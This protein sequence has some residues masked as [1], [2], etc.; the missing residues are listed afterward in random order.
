VV[1]GISFRANR[2]TES[3]TGIPERK[4]ALGK[5]TGVVSGYLPTASADRANDAIA[6][7]YCQ[8]E[9]G[10]QHRSNDEQQPTSRKGSVAETKQ[11][12]ADADRENPASRLTSQHG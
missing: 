12:D 2:R 5:A 10:C 3:T 1:I 4:C 11:G 8:D 6:S 7:D 9:H